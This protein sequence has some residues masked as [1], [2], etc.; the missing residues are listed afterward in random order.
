MK[1]I[2]ENNRVIATAFDGYEGPQ[3]WVSSPSDFVESRA[4][5]YT[6]INGV[7]DL[8]MLPY[9][10]IETQKRL[11]VFAQTRGYENINSATTYINSSVTKYKNEGTYAAT[12]RDSTWSALYQIIEDATDGKRKKIVA[13]SEIVSELPTLV[14]PT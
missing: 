1:L 4:F 14:W 13:F 7:L 11:D 10:E 12:A 2:V 5:E 9:L 3:Q 8:P 6:Y